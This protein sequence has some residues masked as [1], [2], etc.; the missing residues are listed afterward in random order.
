MFKY[1]AFTCCMLLSLDVYA[2]DKTP[3]HAERKEQMQGIRG[4]Q[5]KSSPQQNNR[6]QQNNKNI[7]PEAQNNG[8]G[9]DVRNLE[10]LS[11]SETLA[12]LGA[13]QNEK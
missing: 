9:I 13:N 11:S 10:R 5:Q 12:I 6:K 7:I 4:P 2:G 8:N 3:S 1:I